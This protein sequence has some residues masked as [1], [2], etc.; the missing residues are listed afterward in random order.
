MNRAVTRPGWVEALYP[1][2]NFVQALFLAFW[3]VFCISLAFVAGVVTFRRDLPLSMA[4]WLYS[5]PLIAGTGARLQ[6]EPLPNVDWSKPYIFLMNHQSAL[7]IPLAFACIP[8]NLRF[9][10]K[11]SLKYVP[12]IGWYMWFTGMIFVNRSSRTEAVRSL[13]EAGERIR[14]G[15][16]ILA[17]PEGTR[18]RDGRLLPFKKGPFMVALEAKVPIIPVV[19]EGSGDVLPTGGFKIRSGTV[20]LKLGEPIETAHLRPEDR[21]QLMRQTRDIMIR[22]HQE[23]GGA[24]GDG[25]AI[26]E[27]GVEGR[28]SLAG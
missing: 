21:D 1:L 14:A 20:R 4:R 28:R 11:H 9:I 25:E 19:V 24:G 15:A 12:F 2:L 27:A 5:P 13:R 22:M 18:T 23:L 3:S 6:L 26:A 16:S 8:S 17:Y 7:D 10:A